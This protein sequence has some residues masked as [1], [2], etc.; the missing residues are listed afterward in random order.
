M[1]LKDRSDQINT[2]EVAHACMF[3]LGRLPTPDEF[4]VAITLN[5]E[6][7]LA[8]LLG[9]DEFVSAVCTPLLEQRPFAPDRFR[10]APTVETSAWLA[11]SLPLLARSRATVAATSD[12][13]LL[14][15]LLLSDEVFCSFL[16]L[17]KV[18]W[19]VPLLGAALSKL[20]TRS[21]HRVS[22]ELGAEAV[23]PASL[24]DRAR[25]VLWSL[26]PECLDVLFDV[27]RREDLTLTGKDRMESYFAQPA[28]ER[29]SPSSVF[30]AAY[31]LDHPRVRLPAGADPFCHFLVHADD[32]GFDPHPLI[33]MPFVAEGAAPGQ[34]VIERLCD[35]LA[36]SAQG[37]VH[38][39]LD[40]TFIR[41]QLGGEP[42]SMGEILDRF[43]DPAVSLEI[44]PHPLFSP[45]YYRRRNGVTDRNEL[46]HYLVAGI[47]GLHT[48][49]LVSPPYI[50]AQL[51]RAPDD[52]GTLLERYIGSW[53]DAKVDPSLFVDRNALNDNLRR[54][55]RRPQSEPLSE[56]LADPSTK[57]ALLHPNLDARVLNF[58]F[59]WDDGTADEGVGSLLKVLERETTPPP[60]AGRPLVS[61]VMPTFHKPVYTALSVLA[62][63]NGLRTLPHEIIIIENGGDALHHEELLRLF[64]PHPSVRMV[65]MSH[66]RFFGEGSNIGADLA[67]GEYILFLNNDCFL[68]P[69]F[70]D[71]LAELLASA[72][73]KV[74]VIGSTLLF[75]N[76]DIQ[77][78][79]GF[80]GDDGQ[81]MQTAKHLPASY[82]NDL[83]QLATVGY[84][85]AACLCLSRHALDRVAGFDPLFE[86]LYY[87]DTDLC[88]RL[89]RAGIPIY[90]SR[91]L[92]AAHVENATT[93]EFLG[94]GFEAH[95]SRNRR[96]FA[97]RW[98]KDGGADSYLRPAKIAGSSPKP[99]RALVYTPFDITPGGGERYLLSAAKRLSETHEVVI[100]TSVRTSHARVEF[101]CHA[102]GIRPFAFTT[103]LLSELNVAADPF[104][105]AFVM[106]NEIVPTTL[107][108]A[109]LNLFHVQF[110]YPW[111]NV[112]AYDFTRL[113]GFDSIVVNSPFTAHWTGE[114]LREA[115]IHDAPPIEI[116]APPVQS[117]GSGAVRSP[118][119]GRPIKLVN[120]GRFYEGP[121]S[122]R[123]DI[124]LEVIRRLRGRGVE[125]TGSVFGP[126]VRSDASEQYFNEVAAAAEAMGGVEIVRDASRA[127]LLRTLAEADVYLH[128]AG[129]GV[130][131]S[132]A[133]QD[134]EHFGIVIVEAIQAGCYPVVVDAGGPPDI[135]Q[136]VGCGAVY[137][138]VEQAADAVEAWAKA[139]DRP[140]P[141]WPGE[142]L[143]Q[144]FDRWLSARIEHP[145]Q[146]ARVGRS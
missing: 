56:A 116:V 71:R 102:L 90:A 44:S 140:Q 34:L 112:G 74:D 29:I 94:L 67:K 86:P 81:V 68:A 128:C 17:A 50:H 73:P 14:Y 6:E 47:G 126:V 26:P 19:S 37:S 109:R 20:G 113:S 10:Q 64:V 107:P 130:D 121:H 120:I 51:G 127:E 135:L 84:S 18:P 4:E 77:E 46:L 63:L 91:N 124:F 72:A 66:N 99:L 48:H 108:V 145:A 65:K 15:R 110:P 53:P 146:A 143:D 25:A 89:A 70:G 82:L 8:A 1:L 122:K 13:L 76:G 54:A 104:D 11:Q 80:A 139:D 115:G 119:A 93:R 28:G 133:P 95:V 132:L 22:L 57:L 105:V 75:P 103:E 69:D 131:V 38:P 33:R 52:S 79:G 35:L 55:G 141:A 118:L 134:V 88:R 27:G 58:A 62:A 111:R 32:A 138:T 125:A 137:K 23:A 24:D 100:A 39:L 97:R 87:E 96:A 49:P 78:F 7:Y 142:P 9:S 60:V 31:Y 114:R 36:G 40:V 12:W 61:V 41:D 43:S 123:Q 59:G 98:L 42:L 92:R 83:P 16:D 3:A 85:S 101:A 45:D 2:V 117:I 144:A 136:Q 30:D 106:G 129:F 21:A 5:A